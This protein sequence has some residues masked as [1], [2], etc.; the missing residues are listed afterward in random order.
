MIEVKLD[1]N[2]NIKCK[3]CGYSF[4]GEKQLI[5]DQFCNSVSII[6]CPRCKSIVMLLDVTLFCRFF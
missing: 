4:E 6:K 2:N 3:Q 5:I 1:E